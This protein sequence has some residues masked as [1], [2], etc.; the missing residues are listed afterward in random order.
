MFAEIVT[1]RIGIFDCALQLPSRIKSH[2]TLL[3]FAA[4]AF[5]NAWPAS[6]SVCRLR[7]GLLLNKLLSLL[8]L[9]FTTAIYRLDPY[10]SLFFF[11][12]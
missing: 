5:R 9:L 11:Q 2:G 12:Y 7:S 1:D 6:R 4:G 3:C 10:F 8:Q